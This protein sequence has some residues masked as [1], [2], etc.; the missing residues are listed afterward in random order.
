M[1][2]MQ[3]ITCDGWI[4]AMLQCFISGKESVLKIVN[5]PDSRFVTQRDK[6][7]SRVNCHFAE[8]LHDTL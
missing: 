2:K 4:V 8:W 1:N 5:P 7:E 6:N 3:Y